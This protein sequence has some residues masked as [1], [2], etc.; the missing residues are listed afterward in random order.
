MRVA[1]IVLTGRDNAN[2][3]PLEHRKRQ[4]ADVQNDMP[5]IVVRIVSQT[6]VTLHRQFGRFAEI[7]KID[8]RFGRADSFVLELCGKRR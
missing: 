4:S 7:I 5:N 3:L 2:G 1:S 6:E 8:R